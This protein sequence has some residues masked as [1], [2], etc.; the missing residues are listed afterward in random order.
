MKSNWTQYRALNFRIGLLLSLGLA[1]AAFEWKTYSPMAIVDLTGRADDVEE[2][3]VL[4]P[5]TQQTPPPPPPAVMP[6]IVEI[7]DTEVEDVVEL[8]MEAP[9]PD[10]AVVPI[11]APEEEEI[12]EEDVPTQPVWHAEVPAEPHGGMADFLAYVAKQIEYPRQARRMTIQGRVILEFVVDE[13]GQIGQVKV[14][15]G[16]GAGCDEEAVRVLAAAPKWKP[17]KQ[18]GRPVKQRM[19]FPVFFKLQ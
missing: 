2:D 7:T 18:R 12:E 16:I 19:T 15:R 17:A 1:F 11:E 9:E 14:V 5:P 8:V 10:E 3:L 4:P 13:N 6:Q